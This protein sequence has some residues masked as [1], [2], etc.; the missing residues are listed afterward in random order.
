MA[1]AKTAPKSKARK[2]AP[3]RKKSAARKAALRKKAPAKKK[4]AA[5]KPSRYCLGKCA[6]C[7]S[8]CTYNGGHVLPHYCIDHAP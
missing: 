7:G 1:K 6:T 3:K 2:S 5:P 4:A 8:P